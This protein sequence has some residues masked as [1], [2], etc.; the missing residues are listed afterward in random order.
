MKARA[1]ICVFFFGVLAG[2]QESMNYAS[3]GGRVTDMSGGVVGDAAVTARQVDTNQSTRAATDAEGRFRFPYLRPGRYELTVRRAGFADFTRDVTL[4]IGSAFE[5]PVTLSVETAGSNVLVTAESGALETARSQV[6]VTIPQGEVSS[7]PLNGRNFL[8]LALLVPGVSPANTANNQLFAETSAVPGQGISV[9]SQRNFSN[10]FIVDGLSAND[11]AAGVSG[12]SYGLSTVSEFQVVTSGAQAEFGRALGGYINIVT[13]SGNND[14]HGELYGFFRNQ[15]LNA[16]NALSHAA[17]PMTQ[18]QYGA[19]LGGPVSHD[20]TFYF[21]NVEQRRLNQSGLITIAPANAEIINSRLAEAGYPGE[22]IATG[23]YPNPVHSTHALMKVDHR[24]SARD[25]LS[26]RYTDYEVSSRNSRGAGGLNASSASA[27]LDNADHTIAF[28]NIAVLTPRIVN[29]TRAQYTHSRLDAPP[30]DPTGPAVSISGVATFGTLSGSPTGRFNDLYEAADNISYQAGVHALRAGFSFLRNSTSITYPRAVRGSYSF[31]SLANFLAG[32]YNNSGFT[33][34][35]GVSQVVQTNPNLGVY[36]QDEWKL[37]PRFVLN[38]GVR[39]DLQFLETIRTDT[40]NISPRAGFAWT[41]SPSRRTVIRGSF[42]LYYDRV[43]LRA[44]ANAILSAGNSANPA[45]LRQLSTSLSTGQAGAPVFPNILGS[46]TLPPG[47]LFN[48]T[49][50][51]RRMQNAYSEQGNLEIE[52]QLGE[53]AGVSIGYQH[54]RGLHLIA[55]VNQNAPACVAAGTNNGCRPN[56][57]YGNNSRYSPIGDSRYDGLHVS[58]VQRPSRWGSYRVSYTYSKALD[59]VGEFFF[60]SPMNNYDIWQDYARSD[61][62]QRHRFVFNGVLQPGRGIEL[63]GTLQYYSGLPFNIVTG[64][65]TIQGTPARPQINGVYI[66]RNAGAGFNFF[67]LNLRASR[68]F[69]LTERLRM[70]AIAESFNAL[71]HTN[72]ITLNNTFGSGAYPLA[73]VASFRQTTAAADPRSIQLA[74]HFIF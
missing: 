57:A 70:Q 66:P 18:A 69:H 63:G 27:G 40:N 49:T 7:V 10:S 60:S 74:L 54:L 41:P 47:I 6:A 68:T 71:N 34:T 55:A 64:S 35:F 62:D 36:A 37:T 21:T 48:L 44:L 11:D 8:D 72:G 50:M 29:E 5:L 53:H 26:L 56:P 43:P 28:G 20:R 38:F 61:D 3:V 65:A 12:A 19:S 46:L 14:I 39:Y 17:L 42:G 9:S 13:R 51:D 67:N 58:F 25:S 45:N 73:P 59:D 32:T 30:T 4:T 52:H 24:F 31:S 22:R 33:Q 2:A 1:L 15:R 23:V 16:A